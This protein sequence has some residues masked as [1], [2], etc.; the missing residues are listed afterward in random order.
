MLTHFIGQ[1]DIRGLIVQDAVAAE[2]NSCQVRSKHMLLHLDEGNGRTTLLRYMTEVFEDYQ[3]RRFLNLDTCIEERLPP[4]LNELRML[5]M[6]IGSKA[7]FANYFSGVIALDASGLDKCLNDVEYMNA[8]RQMV[9]NLREHAL[10]IFFLPEKPYNKAERIE[11]L[12]EE[13]CEHYVVNL[14][15]CKYSADELGA[16]LDMILA[17]NGISEDDRRYP[18]NAQAY[19]LEHIDELTPYALK[20]LV[21]DIKYDALYMGPED[22]V[23]L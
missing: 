18:Q 16:I 12:L 14:P 8:F 10:L 22:K 1:N 21:R 2:K 11:Q 7:V 13:L 23:I 9:A 19:I 3:V 15:A 20:C 5:A 17:E 6:R 4:T